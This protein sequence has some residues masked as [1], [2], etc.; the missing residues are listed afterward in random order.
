MFRLARLA[1][2][3][4]LQ[5]RSYT[6][7]ALYPTSYLFAGARARPTFTPRQAGEESG[8]RRDSRSSRDGDGRPGPSNRDRAPRDTRFPR[9]DRSSAPCEGSRSGSFSRGAPGAVAGAA[10]FRGSRGRD[11]NRDA[12]GDRDRDRNSHRSAD[13]P[14]REWKVRGMTPPTSTNPYTLSERVKKYLARHPDRMTRPQIDEMLAI[15]RS[16]P[17]SMSTA[18]VWNLVLSRMGRDGYHTAMWKAFN[19]MKKRGTHASSRTFTV[20]LNAYAGVAHSGMVN[21]TFSPAHRPERL[22]LE[23]VRRIYD[24]S[25]AHIRK[26]LSKASR[27]E[28]SRDD[29]GVAYPEGEE[30]EAPMLPSE[31][32]S[33]WPT[34][35]YLKFLGRYG[36]WTEMEA[37]FLAM[38]REGPLAPDAATYYTMLS[39]ANNVDHYRRSTKEDIG[40]PVIEVGSV[41]RGYFD[42][43]VRTLGG[44]LDERLALAALSCF[45]AGSPSDQRVAEELVPRLWNLPAPGQP[46]SAT[47]VKGKYTLLPRAWATLPTLKLSVRSATALLSTLRRMGNKSLVAHYTRLV[48]E[49]PLARDAD[50]ALLRTFVHNLSFAGDADGASAILETFQPPSGPDGWPADVYLSVLGAARWAA[51]WDIALSTFRRMVALPP[52]AEGGAGKYVWKAPNG[53]GQDVRGRAWVPP[54]PHDISAPA[55]GLLFKTALAC[56]KH[57]IRP[58]RAAAD[59]YDFF[60]P[61]AFFEVRTSAGVVDMNAGEAK[62]WDLSG[63]DYR[64]IGEAVDFARELELVAERLVETPRSPEDKAKH[65]G[66]RRDA[67][68]IVRIWGMRVEE[69]GDRKPKARFLRSLD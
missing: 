18:P 1:P 57:G 62:H 28:G 9:G 61:D 51:D 3:R 8:P 56:L 31:E 45:A 29:L 50:L 21:E 25:Q 7:G 43:A 40:L 42:Q 36:M 47:G 13:R 67:A 53:R 2:V 10:A 44:D 63:R 23:R 16:A 64:M 34:N 54:R 48:A 37:V 33:V 68:R 60:G 41:G 6:G 19:E 32:V 59:I 30:G 12:R 15:V 46:A 69:R 27:N 39:T 35:A 22:T 14:A 11:S 55:M 24:L 49:G 5:T 65:E 38:D 66:W 4:P 20:L 26:M 52:A 58:L 17:P